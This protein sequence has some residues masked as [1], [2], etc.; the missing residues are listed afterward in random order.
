MTSEGLHYSSGN[1]LY[2]A[3]CG[4]L[5]RKEIQKKR[6]RYVYMQL[7]HFAV[8]QKVTQRCK[9]ITHQQKS[10]KKKQESDLG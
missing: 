4:D 8:Q 3:L 10:I 5:T 2:S 7:V 6:G 1:S 9:A